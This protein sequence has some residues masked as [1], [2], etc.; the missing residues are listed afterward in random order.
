MDLMASVI[1][2]VAKRCH[3]VI[4]GHGSQRLLR[5]FEGALHVHIYGSMK[6]R[7]AYMVEEQG[8]EPRSSR[9]DINQK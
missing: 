3:G 4:I 1:Y 7:I 5:N 2:E 9:K 8:I 6:K